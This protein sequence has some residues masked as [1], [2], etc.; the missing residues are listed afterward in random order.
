MICA[1][2]RKPFDIGGWLCLACHQR[3]IL[4]R[5]KERLSHEGGTAQQQRW[6]Q[7]NRNRRADGRLPSRSTR[8]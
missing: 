4:A 6:R 5:E 8:E 7:Y 1:Y 2:C 3:R